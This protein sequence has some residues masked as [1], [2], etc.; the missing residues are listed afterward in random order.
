MHQFIF[1]VQH[2]FAVSLTLRVALAQPRLSLWPAHAF[3][4]SLDGTCCVLPQSESACDL[5]LRLAGTRSNGDRVVRERERE[6]KSPTL[7]ELF[8]VNSRSDVALRHRKRERSP[9]PVHRLPYDQRQWK[10]ARW[11]IYLCMMLEEDRRMIGMTRSRTLMASS[12]I[13]MSTLRH[14]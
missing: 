7:D 10:Y 4:M 5:A 2:L 13:P 14:P 9:L 1:L 12:T 11:D 3:F 8:R 6:T